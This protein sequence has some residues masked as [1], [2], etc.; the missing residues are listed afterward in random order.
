M[1]KAGIVLQRPV[2]SNGPFKEHSDLPSAKSLD[3][4]PRKDRAPA[5]K[6]KTVSSKAPRLSEKA[7]RK[8]A[9]AFER[10]RKR[11][12]APREKE[13]AE[14]ARVCAR[15]EA[16]ILQAEAAFARQGGTRGHCFG[17]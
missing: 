6:S 2:G 5:K 3:T 10:E 15:R 14:A 8:A 1:A 4:P 7:E 16:A 11:Q 12:Q 13:E 9:I 17:D